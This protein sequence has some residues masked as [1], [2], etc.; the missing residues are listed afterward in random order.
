M[1]VNTILSSTIAQKMRIKTTILIPGAK[2]LYLYRHGITHGMKFSC[3]LI[4]QPP[5]SSPLIV[6]TKNA[7]AEPSV[8][9]TTQPLAEP[10]PGVEQGAAGIRPL[11]STPGMQAPNMS[12][13]TDVELIDDHD[14]TNYTVS[15]PPPH[16]VP[17]QSKPLNI[18]INMIC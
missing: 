9:L 17:G 2:V 1:G 18:L 7:S 13:F 11:V 4:T 16:L 10:S 5:Y 3:V 8:L 6:A 12:A 14:E 15:P